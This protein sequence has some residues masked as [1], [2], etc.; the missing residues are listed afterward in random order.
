MNNEIPF[1]NKRKNQ[2]I[3]DSP[4]HEFSYQKQRSST[5]KTSN[6]ILDEM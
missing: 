5:I 3:F 2:S 1:E 6:E 4:K